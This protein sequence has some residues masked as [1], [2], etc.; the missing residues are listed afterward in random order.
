[1]TRAMLADALG[2]AGLRADVHAGAD[3]RDATP[4]V[5]PGMVERH[6]A[7]RADV[8][9]FDRA[10]LQDVTHGLSQDQ[11]G[12]SAV[13]TLDWSLPLPA[14][15]RA[16]PMPNDPLAYARALYATLHQLDADGVTIVAIERPPDSDAWAGIR[17]R[18]SR[19]A[20]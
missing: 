3:V 8:W 13:L 6:Y 2:R 16:I 4:R 11:P 20:H 10:D 18:L 7:P 5:S 1:I 12:R 17:D 9:L 15:V 19:A 14:Q